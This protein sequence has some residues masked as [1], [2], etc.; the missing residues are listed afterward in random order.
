VN[1]F[2]PGSAT[3][4]EYRLNGWSRGLLLVLGGLMVVGSGPLAAIVLAGTNSAAGVLLALFLFAM[5][6]Y[7][8]A[9]AVRSRLI[10]D[11]TRID[12][13]TAFGDK[14]ANLSAIE[15]FRTLSSRNG[16]YKQ[17]YLKDGQ[18]P[19]TIS[20]SF[21]TDD[22]LR[23]WFARLPDL[24]ERDKQKLLDEISLDQE[25]GATPEERLAALRRAKALNIFGIAFSIAAA[26]ALKLGPASVSLPSAAVLALAPLFVLFLVQRSPLLY[27]VFKRRADPRADLSAVLLIAAFGFLICAGGAN[28]VSIE[29]ILVIAGSISLVLFAALY[30]TA[31][32]GSAVPGSLV[33]FLFLSAFY[34]FGLASVADTL[35]DHSTPVTYQIQVAGKHVSRGKSTTCYLDLPPWGPIYHPNRISVSSSVYRNTIA[36]DP[37]CLELRSGALRAAWYKRV[38]CANQPEWSPPQ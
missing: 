18:R 9:Y 24:D 38:D 20:Q 8:L 14:T 37:V 19:I 25:L 1:A 32:N 12:V 26:A 31:R 34:G 15:G 5:G 27:S 36:G 11:G 2:Q 13:R 17:L 30:I 10:I 4:H 3:R 23:A 35:A 6:A 21:S 28:F 33:A 7:L 22:D 16:V 29:S